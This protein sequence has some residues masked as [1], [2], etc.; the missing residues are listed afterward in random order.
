MHSRQDIPALS[1]AYAM[2]VHYGNRDDG[3]A[4]ATEMILAEEMEQASFVR[5][6]LG[7]LAE[8]D[9]GDELVAAFRAGN[10]TGLAAELGRRFEAEARDICGAFARAQ[11]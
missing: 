11:N 7:N 6:V 3:I 2:A 4:I 9:I 5:Q 10:I 1:N 8:Q